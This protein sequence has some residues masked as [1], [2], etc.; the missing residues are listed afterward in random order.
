MRGEI[1]KGEGEKSHPGL[2]ELRR[3]LGAQSLRITAAPCRSYMP[4]NDLGFLA[5]NKTENNLG[6]G[7]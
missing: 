4:V 3:A 2:L 7:G 1:G 6:I 5:K